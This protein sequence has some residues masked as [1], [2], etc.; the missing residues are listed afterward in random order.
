[1]PRPCQFVVA[2]LIFCAVVRGQTPSSTS[3][4]A[5]PNP[6]NYGQPVTL[7]ATVT[8]GATG[9][10]TF[11]DGVTLLGVGTLSGGQASISTVMLPSGNRSLRAYYH[12]NGSYA[13]SSSTPLAQTVTTARSLGFASTV[14]YPAASW[15]QA[16][17]VSD[18][19][20][21]NKQDFVAIT[22][23]NS[24]TVY[25]GNGD[26]TFQ[27]GVAYA[28]G[29]VPYSIVVSDFN[30][31]GV[32]DIAVANNGSG[33]V[34][35]LLGNG[36]GTFRSAVNYPAGSGVDVLAVADFNG[37]GNADLVASSTLS[38]GL[39][40]LLGNGDGTLQPPVS[41]STTTYPPSVS[42][43]DFNG[44]ERPDLLVCGNGTVGL[45][46]GNG[47]GTFQVEQTISL[48]GAYAYWTATADF[49][50]DGHIDIL[51]NTS[52][53][54][55]V[56]LG[57]GDGV[58]GAPL[59]SNASSY[60]GAPVIADFYGDGKLDLAFVDPGD[61]QV[62]GVGRGTVWVLPGNG[63]GTFQ[64]ALKYIAPAGVTVLAAGDFNGDGKVDVLVAEGTG[65]GYA[66][67]LG[68]AL[69][70]L[71]I[72]VST[73]GFTEGQHGIPYTITVS[74]V[75]AIGSVGTVTVGAT[76][77]QG[78]TAQTL[79]GSGWTCVLANLQC[80]RDDTVA[81]GA[82]YPAIILTVNIA[83]GLTGS[84]TS[85]FTVSG[86][87]ETNT[88]ND[89]VSV[90]SFSR[91][92][93]STLV[94]ASPNPS[95]LGQTVSLTATVTAAATGHVDFYDGTSL[96]GSAPVASGQSVF[97]TSLLPSG[98]SL[99]TAVYSGDSTYGPSTSAAATQTVNPVPV[100]GL[101]PYASY[102]V[103]HEPNWIT[104]TDLN[105]DGKADLLTANSGNFPNGSISVLLGNGDG[106]FRPAVTYSI[107]NGFGAES[108]VVADFNHDGKPDVAV[109]TENGVFVLLGNGDGTFQTAQLAIPPSPDSFYYADLSSADFN[110]DGIPD[111]VAISSGVIV[112]FLG[113][114]DGTFQP[115]VNLTSAS[116][117]A[118]QVTDMNGDGKADLVV[119]NFSIGEVS[120]FLGNGDGTFA[121]PMNSSA[122]F[123]SIAALVVGDYNG[124]HKPDV[125]VV[126]SNGV[127]ALLGNGDG[128]LGLPI[129]SSLPVQAC[130]FAAAGDFN[131]DG[132][133]DLAFDGYVTNSVNLL[134]GNGDGTFNVGPSLYLPVST[135][136]LA[137]G[138]F[139]RDG[140]LDFALTNGDSA[141]DVFLGGQFSG[142]AITAV[143]TGGFTAGQSGS[144]QITVA[145]DQFVS[146]AG[147]VNLT[148]TLPV[149]LT[150]AAIG[151]TGWTCT[152]SPLA[153]TRSDS[154]GT[155]QSYPT[156][157]LTV[158]IAADLPPST[159]TNR[160]S[161][162]YGATLNNATVITH[163][164]LPTQTALTSSPNPATFGQPVILTASV[165]A[166]ATGSVLF[167]DNGAALGSAT[168]TAGQAVLATRL[169]PSGL[170]E[171]MAIYS[172]DATHAPSSTAETYQT[173]NASPAN[174]FGPPFTYTTGAGPRAIA[175]GDF[176]NDGHT[177]LVT[178]NSTANTVSVLLGHGDGTFGASTDYAVGTDPVAFAVADF[179]G[180]GQPDIAV[181]NYG[182]N[183]VSIL[184]GN[185]DGTF[186]TATN[187]AAGSTPYL[188]AASDFNGDGK[189]DLVLDGSGNGVTFLFGNGDGTFQPAV[190]MGVFGGSSFAVGDFNGD[191]KIDIFTPF[192]LLVG[193][194]NGSFQTKSLLSG[195]LF[196][197]IAAGDLNGDG[198]LDA[199]GA[200]DFGVTVF[201]GNGDGTFQ[202]GVYYTGG[203][204][205]TS[206]L[207][208]DVNGDGKL[209]V[210]AADGD[211][212]DV[213]LGNGDGTLQPATFVQL[214]T[215]PQSAIAGN[216]NGD[217]R[218][219]LAT[220]SYL[221]NGVTVLLGILTPTFTVS[222]SHS[223]PFSLGQT[224][225]TYTITVTNTG[226][227]VTSSTVTV[228]DT[229]PAGLAA[230]AIQGTGWNCTLATLTCTYS[231]SLSVGQS[232]SI[233]IS[234]TPT[235]IGTGAN[236]VTVSGG[237]AATTSASDPT[238]IVGPAIT[239]QTVP[240]GLQFSI[241][242]AALQKAPQ[243]INLAPG[244]HTLAVASTQTAPG[245]EYLFSN[246]SDDS[247][248]ASR[249]ITVGNTAA[250]YTASF[251]TQYR[252]T[253]ASY[254][255]AGGSVTPASGAYYNSGATITL[256]ATPNSPLVFTGWSGGVTG[257]TNPLQ[258]A[259]NAPVSVTAA[260]DVPGATCTMTGDTTASVADA[261]FIVN[262]A[263][264]IIPAN[265]DLNGDGVV[266]IA[267]VQRVIG[268]ILGLRCIY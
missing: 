205:P 131:G 55:L 135:P 229:L 115:P 45:L 89:T 10:V 28:V 236:Q 56:F 159:L 130:C 156:I 162:S 177:D 218:T 41:V 84:L 54:M 108:A 53:S 35:I 61:S 94:T 231:N 160:A 213:F 19:N 76:L 47:D 166:G 259:M 207:L 230:T 157:T 163:T 184:L 59:T 20:R 75:G 206:V 198:K 261:Q 234:V 189:V 245:T 214:G 152:L 106:T 151:G 65:N 260:F 251:Q 112:L 181:A 88:A 168:I 107:P 109:S 100:N 265:N 34:S 197:S 2:F 258:I 104:S 68:G 25:L 129:Q 69:P 36:D 164:V 66:V 23:Y 82:S 203:V 40:V 267:D 133:L 204:Q 96:L 125:A 74:N 211:R 257:T 256:S 46:L 172:G 232:S 124:D 244:T 49:N 9:K 86:G 32:P 145:D 39:V 138:D 26:G 11:Y 87:G 81:V 118:L 190:Q 17:A 132:K 220:A 153:C 99:F 188:L 77:P 30:G 127:A 60:S 221:S 64:S 16:V 193:Q 149:G 105:L 241:D 176:N 80:T 90:T 150:A 202:P 183:N 169:L 266:N 154:I 141:V 8:S 114:G 38:G 235:A 222:S 37:D 72:A 240:S 62:D 111:L 175:S 63:D 233:I 44:D 155:G 117:E 210:V 83:N 101:L 254:P 215:S 219:D 15:F 146:T 185:P 186:Q 208:A 119:Y 249:T 262:E 147:T 158:N 71:T 252:L 29:D 50:G 224:G 7:T 143:Q 126:Y 246:W 51:V 134:F 92:G 196:N 226:P 216:F 70:D 93:T 243:T 103:D 128:T 3:L 180:D 13:P 187:F 170:Q 137:V 227:G 173:V 67:L 24:V 43:A 22:A 182:S 136:S 238:T 31:D 255:Q 121:S 192:S 95:Q 225:A 12:G 201:L 171:L 209:D 194:D 250:T 148:D 42:V 247:V 223:D 14:E 33:N 4:S 263:L 73:L 242:N 102:T 144:Y 98:V 27:N 122:I 179:N 52:S 253:T 212:L 237:G 195:E 239:V 97:M 123:I 18:F 57:N 48:G 217:G 79:G 161:V 78:L 140:K 167:L 91:Y 116:Y 142:L 6:S 199:V 264:G 110:G 1:M 85:S 200:S 191:G 174:G 58:F 248:A 178:A 228:T 165:T 5:S 139:N 120:V 268:A 113:N 21:D